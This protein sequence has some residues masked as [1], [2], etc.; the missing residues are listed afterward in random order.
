MRTSS[1]SQRI[2]V[3]V[4]GSTAVEVGGL[5]GVDETKRVQSHALEG[6]R[7]KMESQV[8]PGLAIGGV[9]GV[10]MRLCGGKVVPGGMLT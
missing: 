8:A 6:E 10:G 4:Q 3:T 7:V 2:D 1:R 9:R 5:M